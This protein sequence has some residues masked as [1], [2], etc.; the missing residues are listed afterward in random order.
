MHGSLL[1]KTGYH[2]GPTLLFLF[3]SALF[4]EGVIVLPAPLPPPTFVTLQGSSTLTSPSQEVLNNKVKNF[5][6]NDTDVAELVLRQED[7]LHKHF[8]SLVLHL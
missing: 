1:A 8:E 6:K 2:D 3:G 5:Y 7:S 4:L